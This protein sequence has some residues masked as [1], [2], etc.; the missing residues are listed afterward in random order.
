MDQRLTVR[1][2]AL[3]EML[4]MFTDTPFKIPAGLLADTDKL[5][6]KFVWKCR[7]QKSQNNLEREQSWR[8]HTSQ[9]QILLESH[10]FQ[11]SVELVEG[12]AHRSKEH[13]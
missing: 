4:Y 1:M 7:T 5:I 2:A 12:L 11:D 9:C 10:I 13:K 8:I 3:P 6:L